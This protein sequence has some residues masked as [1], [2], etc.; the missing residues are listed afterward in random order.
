M[1]GDD[2][3]ARLLD[4]A[5]RIIRLAQ[6]LPKNPV[7]RHVGGQLMRCGTAAGSNYKE[8]R[9]AES[10]ADFVHKLAVSWKET[11][12]SCF[13]LQLIQRA[14]LLKPSRLSALLKEGDELS[15]ILSRSL[16]TARAKMH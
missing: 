1:K 14:E 12:K 10:R 4:F 9:G 3:S 11:R 13:W 5:V 2:I 6:A 15:A 7:A 8:A 16:K